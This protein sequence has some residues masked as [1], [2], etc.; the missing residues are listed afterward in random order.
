VIGV[1]ICDDHEL[2]RTGMR[3]R[4]QREP[5]ISVVGEAGTAEQALARA[6]VLPPDFV[7][8]DLL[9]PRTSGYE[10]IPDLV[11]QAPGSRVLVVS[12][13]AAPSWV[14]RARSA[15]AAG[16]LPKR[17][18]DRDLLAAIRRIASGEGYVDPG[19][20]AKLVVDAALPALAPLSA[21]E[22]DVLHSLALGYTNQEIAARLF[23][24]VRT[25]D[26]HRAHIMQKPRPRDPSRAG[27]VRA[28][29]RRHRAVTAAGDHARP[30]AEITISGMALHSRGSRHSCTPSPSEART[31]VS[32]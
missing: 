17:A 8:L 20:G 24:S 3:S 16:Y 2:V 26:T 18:S 30:G 22:R 4:L 14:R 15:G 10:M 21:R 11:R 7:L 27:H 9:M 13:Q 29:Q 25:V 5:D 31:R 32:P 28:G 12:A 19:L 23:I 1:L 6:R